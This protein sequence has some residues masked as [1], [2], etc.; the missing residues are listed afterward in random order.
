MSSI[1]LSNPQADQHSG[2]PGE[3]PP[4]QGKHFGQDIAEAGAHLQ[5]GRVSEPEGAPAQGGL[6]EA[7]ADGALGKRLTPSSSPPLFP[8]RAVLQ[9][10]ALFPVQLE[11]VSQEGSRSEKQCS[12]LRAEVADL[13]HKLSALKEKVSVREQMAKC[14][15]HN[16][17]KKNLA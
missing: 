12:E 5:P 11:K 15:S 1:H 9:L 3:L 6:R 10:C 14:T 2:E 7:A 4:G 16:E 8:P 13:T 17:A